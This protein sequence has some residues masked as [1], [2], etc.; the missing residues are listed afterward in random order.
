MADV[1][2]TLDVRR[3]RFTVEEY[4]RMAEVGILGPEDRVELIEGEII[5]MSPIGPRHAYCVSSLTTLLI[6]A[7]GDRAVLWAQNPVLLPRDSVPQPDIVLLHP[8]LSQYGQR[9]PQPGDVSLLVEVADT[10]YRFDREVKLRIYAAA[11][12]AEFWI[13]DL[14]HD[15]VEIFRNPEGRRYGN[16]E[17][18]GLGRRIAPAAFPDATLSVEEILPPA[19]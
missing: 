7:L 19:A 2:A 18:V 14:A 16:T 8:P 10:S 4:Y 12:I 6:R 5:Q 3:R 11:G 17:R 15:V 9:L 13:V 1:L